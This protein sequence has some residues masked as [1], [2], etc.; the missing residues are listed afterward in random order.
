MALKQLIKLITPMINEEMGMYETDDNESY[1]N[2]EKL[3]NKIT[4]IPDG[5][6]YDKDFP[7][8]QIPG[9]E[10]APE[11][12]EDGEN[13]HIGPKIKEERDL[14][15]EL[16]NNEELVISFD[17]TDMENEF[18]KDSSV[19]QRTFGN[20][21]QLPPSD[22]GQGVITPPLPSANNNTS[23]IDIDCKHRDLVKKLL[24]YIQKKK[25]N[26]MES[27]TEGVY[28]GK[29]IKL[30]TVYMPK[31]SKRRF[32]LYL[33]NSGQILKVNFGPTEVENHICKLR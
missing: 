16:M 7:I 9:Q 21:P 27:L 28:N 6:D 3:S 29:N 18:V 5:I 20:T 10:E 12:S 23:E 1:R 8:T 11:N 31:K 24:L 17:V 15:E 14:Y 33:E 30:N 25:M 4:E 22:F 19:P 2:K 32:T 13:V 26:Q